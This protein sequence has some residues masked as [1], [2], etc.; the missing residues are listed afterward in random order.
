VRLRQAFHPFRFG[1]QILVAVIHALLA[2]ICALVHDRARRPGDAPCGK[3]CAPAD[4]WIIHLPVLGAVFI[5]AATA[6]AVQVSVFEQGMHIE[7]LFREY[8]SQ[9]MSKKC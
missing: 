8:E 5:S 2:V 3:K 6:A 7:M 4:G 1:Y 9:K